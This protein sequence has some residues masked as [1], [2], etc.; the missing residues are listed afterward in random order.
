MTNR[1]TIVSLFDGISCGRE[2]IRHCKIADKNVK[3]YASEIDPVA[4]RVAQK[5][6]PNITQIGDVRNVSYKNGVLHTKTGK[7]RIGK[8]HLLLAG[9]PCQGFS[10]N[11][12][13]KLL[14]DERSIL[15]FQFTRILKEIQPTYFLLENVRMPVDIENFITKHLHK[16]NSSLYRLN[17]R[18][19]CAQNRDRLYWT[20]IP[21]DVQFLNN[22]SHRSKQFAYDMPEIVNDGYNGIYHR[23][24]GYYKGGF[25]EKQEKAP[26]ITRSGWLSSFFIHQHGKRRKFTA[27]EC[28][29]LQTL[30]HNYTSVAG[31]DSARV[32]LIGN[33]WTVA[34]I[35]DL[36]REAFPKL[37]KKRVINSKMRGR[38]NKSLRNKKY[39]RKIQHK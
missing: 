31:S 10:T 23:P 36:I 19:W 8:V 11:G 3:Y 6:Y 5:R 17:S 12:T 33:A 30:P 15:F 18:K 28:E 2:A 35:H 7:Y 39:T 22:I 26:C 27:V 13:R 1:Y 20:N 14:Q 9:S 21:N 16:Y 29:E 32:S 25:K 34:V 24:H 37:K 38:A 4:I